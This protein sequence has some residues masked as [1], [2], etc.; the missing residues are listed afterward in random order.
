MHALLLTRLKDFIIGFCWVSILKSLLVVFSSWG[1]KKT[2]CFFNE[3]NSRLSSTSPFLGSFDLISSAVL[4]I[5]NTRVIR[6]ASEPKSILQDLS[7][8]V[9]CFAIGSGSLQQILSLSSASAPVF[10]AC[11]KSASWWES[12]YKE[13]RAQS[14][15]ERAG[16]MR[17]F[18]PCRRQPAVH[19]IRN[20]Q[21]A[22]N[23]NTWPCQI[24]N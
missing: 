12:Q 13:Q 1:H 3:V 17:W 2:N 14:R 21:K 16:E 18:C 9:A 22:P 10:C 15:G 6:D 19:W 20:K 23:V 4:P 7:K 11:W 8:H 5:C 24:R